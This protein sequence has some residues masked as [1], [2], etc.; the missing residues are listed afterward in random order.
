M[1]AV[2]FALIRS[3]R[4]CIAGGFALIVVSIPVASVYFPDGRT[5]MTGPSESIRIVT[6]NLWV[7]NASVQTGLKTL[8]DLDADVLVLTEVTPLAAMYIKQVV[9][10]FP[11]RLVEP[12]ENKYGI[13]VLSQFPLQNARIEAL[14]KPYIPMVRADITVGDSIMHLIAIHL[15]TPRKV[16]YYASRNGQLRELAELAHDMEGPLVV[17][18]DWNTTPWSHAYRR[19]ERESGLR[20]SRQGFGIM[21][22]WSARQP[23]PWFP[24]DQIVVSDGIRVAASHAGPNIGSD[25]LSFIATVEVPTRLHITP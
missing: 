22:T 21:P 24:I 20:N 1:S 2:L 14:G 7:E 8:L 13:A 15:E 19:F 9:L 4:W 16:A 5:T 6:A 23:F 10:G 25:H 17:A 12:R 18:G 11:Y 3:W